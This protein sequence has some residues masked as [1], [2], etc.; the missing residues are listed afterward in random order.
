MVFQENSSRACHFSKPRPTT[1]SVS[2][3]PYS[4]NQS[5]LRVYPHQE[6]G[7]A[8]PHTGR[9]IIEFVAIFNLLQS[10]PPT[11]IC[12][13]LRRTPKFSYHDSIRTQAASGSGS[14]S[15]ILSFTS[16]TSMNMIPQVC[17]IE[18]VSLNM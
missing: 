2:I 13:S 9:G 6:E 1:G 11:R 17:F 14:K 18:Y 8:L 12:S 10:L 4:F 7:I 3:L 15:R 16:G 5:N